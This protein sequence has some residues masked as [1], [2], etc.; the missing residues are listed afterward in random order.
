MTTRSGTSSMKILLS[1]N[2]RRAIVWCHTSTSKTSLFLGCGLIGSGT[3]LVRITKC[4]QIG[5]N[6]W[7]KSGSLGR[8][9]P[10]A[11]HL[12]QNDKLWH[13]QHK[14]L[15]EHKEKIGH[16]NL[17]YQRARHANDKMLPD[18]NELLEVRKMSL[19]VATDDQTGFSFSLRICSK[20]LTS[21]RVSL[22]RHQL[23][24]L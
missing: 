23:L 20:D 2:K 13:Q 7:T 16:C 4:D 1:L 12:H 19:V 22:S 18:Q 3:L 8:M 14:K 11:P 5:R 21:F 15:L 6:F 17:Q 10:P 9:T 24:S